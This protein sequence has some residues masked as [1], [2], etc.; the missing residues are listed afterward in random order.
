MVQDYANAVKQ[1]FATEYDS[2]AALRSPPHITLQAPFE[3][4]LEEQPQ[5]SQALAE[6]AQG[7]VPVPIQLKGF[8]AFPPRVIYLHIERTPILLASQKALADELERRFEICDPRKARPFRPHMTVGFRDLKRE[9]FRRAWAKFEAQSVEFEFTVPNL[10]LL[11]HDGKRWNAVE[12]F[13]LLGRS[14]DS[15]S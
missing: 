6:F 12:D 13:P 5:L 9:N 8:G 3:W 7:Q 2:R 4:N 14:L 15:E 1:V 10:T 11:L